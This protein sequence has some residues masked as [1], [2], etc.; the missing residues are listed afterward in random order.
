MK[1]YWRLVFILLVLTGGGSLCAAGENNPEVVL[2]TNFGEIVVELF[3]D[4]A[5]ITVHNFLSYVNSDYYDGLVF[6]RVIEDFMIQGGVYY[7]EGTIIYYRPPVF[8]PII[9]E[10]YNGLS[11]IRGTVAMART[12]EPDSATSQFFINHVDNLYLDRENASDGF[13]YCVFGQVVSGMSVVDSIAQTPTYYVDPSLTHFP[14]DPTVDIYTAYE[15]PCEISYCSDMSYDGKIDFADF[16]IFASRW[17]DSGCDWTN[18]FCDGTDLNYNGN[19]NIEDLELFINNWVMPVGYETQLSDLVPDG[20]VNVYDLVILVSHWLE[21][22][23][24]IENGFCNRTDLNHSGTVDI[25][26]FELFS[27]N[28]MRQP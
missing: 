10:S 26:D 11:N 18:D 27:K 13:G 22:G 25:S 14:Y 6:H 9:N 15:K 17:L 8:A 28:W 1:S 4:D 5:P 7:V 12:D 3:P 19:C 24:G 20:E 21:N 23:C 16:S 2:V